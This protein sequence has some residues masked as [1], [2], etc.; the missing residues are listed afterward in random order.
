MDSA[1]RMAMQ[2]DVE[3]VVGVP[4]K[5]ELPRS[6]PV[7]AAPE[8]EQEELAE[9][10]ETEDQS[11]DLSVDA[12]EET[13]T[14]NPQEAETW[15]MPARDFVKEVGLTRAE[16]YNNVTLP[17]DKGE[18]SL[19][20]VLDDYNELTQR[21]ST[22]TNE[23]T[24][25]RQQR[26]EISHQASAMQVG[27]QVS[28]EV[29]ELGYEY[30]QLENQYYNA[31][32][33]QY[34]PDQRRDLKEQLRDRMDLVRREM[35]T[36]Q[37]QYDYQRQEMLV[38]Y[39]REIEAEKVKLIGAWVSPDVR[40]KE[41]PEIDKFLS[42]QGFS[43]DRIAAVHRDPLSLRLVRNAWKNA[44]NQAEITTGAKKIRKLSKAF[45]PGAKQGKPTRSLAEAGKRVKEPGLSRLERQKRRMSVQFDL[46][47]R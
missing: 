36:K 15:Q 43:P 41:T 7:E 12:P 1:E 19:S 4:L 18:Q 34:D 11:E 27:Q 32:W 42:S 9:Q 37:N 46:P 29:Q 38:K 22:L 30:K 17:T 16:F 45:K 21:V 14:E 44:T 2:F 10:P 28:P 35:N 5:P 40:N 6:E 8:E 3:P 13:D 39:Q 26:E 33:D 47:T 24:T 25:E 31:P 23:L 20:A